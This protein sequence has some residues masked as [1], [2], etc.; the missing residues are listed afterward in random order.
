V[1]LKKTRKKPDF[2]IVVNPNYHRN[3]ISEANKS[4]IPVLIV[5]EFSAVP[6]LLGFLK[7]AGVSLVYL[8]LLA[9]Y[10]AVEMVLFVYFLRAL[11]IKRYL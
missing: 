6:K 3:V 1:L 8:F 11:L 5:A 7:E 10:S 4:G 2:I 9:A